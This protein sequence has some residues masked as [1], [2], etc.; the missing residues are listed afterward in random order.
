MPCPWKRMQDIMSPIMYVSSSLSLCTAWEV[1]KLTVAPMY[2][3][4]GGRKLVLT[5]Y[6]P[7]LVSGPR[8]HGSGAVVRGGHGLVHVH[9]YLRDRARGPGSLQDEDDKF[10]PSNST[11]FPHSR[12]L[13]IRFERRQETVM[14]VSPSSYFEINLTVI[15]PRDAN[16]M[17][18]K[19]TSW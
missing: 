12:Y 4:Q 7:P 15:P 19:P 13:G 3:Q 18:L 1:N 8:L 16:L 14:Q 10:S 6:L 11:L 5:V 2:S 17:S 9:H